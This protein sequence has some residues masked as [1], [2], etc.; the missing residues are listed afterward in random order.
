MSMFVSRRLRPRLLARGY[1][2]RAL[3]VERLWTRLFTRYRR[4]RALMRRLHHAT[5]ASR[6]LPG[7]TLMAGCLHGCAA[8]I[9]CFAISVG[10]FDNATVVAVGRARVLR[11][12]WRRDHA[13]V[14]CRR[15][16]YRVRPLEAARVLGGEDR[17]MP[18]VGLEALGRI[19]HCL[20]ALLRLH[21]RRL[22]PPLVGV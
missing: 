12:L 20:V 18:P 9:R 6:G 13:G 11:A 15:P 3:V 2:L 1:R 21:G 10:C 17:G 8:A 4:S 22:E 16:G 19:V 7:T 5:I 14:G